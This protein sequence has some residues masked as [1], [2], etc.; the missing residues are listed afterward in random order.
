MTV[1]IIDIFLVLYFLLLLESVLLLVKREFVVNQ[2]A[3]LFQQQPHTSYAY[4]TPCLHQEAIWSS[5]YHLGLHGYTQ[6]HC[7]MVHFSE[8]TPV[9]Q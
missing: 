8:C 3:V 4:H 1:L 5:P 6:Q 7:L 9:I 2:H